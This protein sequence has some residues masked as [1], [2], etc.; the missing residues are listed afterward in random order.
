MKPFYKTTVKKSTTH[1]AN[2][3]N[4]TKPDYPFMLSVVELNIRLSAVMPTHKTTISPA[5][6]KHIRSKAFPILNKHF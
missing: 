5:D 1:V 2:S 6:Y 3:I 4:K